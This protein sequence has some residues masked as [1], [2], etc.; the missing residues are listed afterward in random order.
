MSRITD[1]IA[2]ST[3]Q[4]WLMSV[5]SPIA[6]ATAV[7]P[8][9]SG[10]TAA[11][12]AP[13]AITSTSSVMGSDRLSAFLKS[14]SKT[15]LSALLAL[16]SP[17]SSMRNCGWRAC[18]VATASSTEPTRSLAWFWSPRTSKLTSALV[19]SA[20][21]WPSLPAISGDLTFRTNRFGRTTPITSATAARKAGESTLVWPL[22]AAMKT[23]S[24]ARSK[25]PAAASTLA[26]CPD[27]RTPWSC[28]WSVLRPSAPESAMATTTAPSQPKIATL[29]CCAD[30]WAARAVRLRPCIP[31]ILS[32]VHDLVE[33]IVT[34]GAGGREVAVL[35]P[36]DSEALLDEHAFE[37]DEFI[38][39]WAELWPSGVALARAIA[40]RSLKGARVLELGC[41]LG[42]PSIAAAQGGGRVLATDWSPVAID[43]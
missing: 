12:S 33:E 29:R 34:L 17:N 31:A 37:A 9:T 13:K 1:V 40:G 36:R 16:A 4:T 5:T 35:R 19:R 27:S 18:A 8:S 2:S 6:M 22:R 42:L 15:L 24:F 3:A 10:S 41:G 23:F 28:A 26:A 38:P 11:T 14:S 32:T 7:R 21:T 43:R 30:Q 20:A 25:K 39:Y